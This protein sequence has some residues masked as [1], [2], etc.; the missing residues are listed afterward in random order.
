M[1]DG[2]AYARSRA[3]KTCAASAVMLLFMPSAPALA[4]DAIEIPS[5]T[6]ARSY[7]PAEFARFAPRNALDMLRQVPGFSIR[8]E[9][10]E[11]GLGQASGNVLIDGKRVSGKSNDAVTELSRVS[12]ANVVRI[13]IVDG[14]TL[15]VP[16]LSGEVA[17]VITRPGGI[18]GQFAWR[19]EFRAHYADPRLTNGEVSLSGSKGPVQYTIGLENNSF[20]G[21]AG[22]PTRILDAGGAIVELRD[23]VFTAN[24]EVPKLSGRFV[25]D[26]PGSA[27]G[28]L[29]LSVEKFIYAFRERGPRRGPGLIDRE[30]EVRADEGGYSYELGGDV[31]VKLGDGRLKLI[32]LERFEREPFAQSVVTSFADDSSSIGSRFAT[33]GKSGERIGRAEYRWK[34]GGADW[35]VSSE[36]AFNSL[37]N[38]SRLFDLSP[39]GDF[40]EVPLPGGSAEVTEDRYEVVGSYGRS[41]SPKLSFQMSA[42]GEYSTLSQSGDNGLTR[43]FLRP[44]GAISVAWKPSPRLGVNAK[45]QRRVGQLDFGSFLASVNISDDRENAGNPNLVPPQSWEAEVEATNSLGR[46]GSAT[47]KLYGQRIDDL[48]DIVPIGE[49]GESPGNIDRASLYGAELKGTLTFDPVGWTGAKLDIQLAAQRSRVEDPLTG[50]ARPISSSLFRR[51]NL[52]L[53]H[54]VPE[55]DWAYGG[56]A[57]Y[58]RNALYVRLTEF[59]RSAEGPVFA[60]LFVEHKDVLG[61]TVRASA[62]NLLDARS[63]FDRTVY[64]GRRTDAIAFVERRNRL[65][66]PIF[67]FS[68]RGDF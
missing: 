37:D 54:D 16:G 43:S 46:W 5:A 45:L 19:P 64:A 4:Q 38:V 3:G 41:L 25:I 9:S 44:K 48:V 33:T 24:G 7:T 55:T 28:N 57:S 49:T 32:G 66:G 36:A 30:R 20:R 31:E 6:G 2:K 13:D 34:G 27:A 21:A 67:S 35:Q 50:E 60:G 65:I 23:D 53:R 17:N 15:D 1:T 39:D 51:A 56:S 40:E 62:N 61:L 22:G 12:A 8:Q 18:K 52:S 26:G 68:L 29:N 63:R 59:G 11:R 14:A 10:Q 47:L 58:Q 42:G